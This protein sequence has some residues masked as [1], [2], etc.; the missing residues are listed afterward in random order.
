M[1]STT[2]YGDAV[3]EI[4]NALPAV[5]LGTGRTA[6]TAV[7]GDDFTCVLLD[8]TNVVC[9]GA[10]DAGQLGRGAAT[11][12]CSSGAQRGRRKVSGNLIFL[13]V[14]YFKERKDGHNARRLK[15]RGIR[16]RW[17]SCQGGPLLPH[18]QCH[19]KGKGHKS[20]HLHTH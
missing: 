5:N 18:V 4:G 3:S 10:N 9:F 2:N 12:G 19:R 7:A 14:S 17:K 16:F 15:V 11:G 6:V 13:C 1:G 8:N 20:S